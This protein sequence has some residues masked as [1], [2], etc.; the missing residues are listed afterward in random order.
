MSKNLWPEI[1][2]VAG[3][4]LGEGFDLICEGEKHSYAP[5]TITEKGLFDSDGDY[6]PGDLIGHIFDGSYTIQ[7]RPWR[8]KNNEVFWLVGI[9]GN[10]LCSCFCKNNVCDLG[11]LNMGNCFPTKEAAEATKPE[12][13]AKF[14][15]IKKGVRE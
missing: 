3:V 2:K 15:E 7:K 5:Y 14:E 6:V 10:V 12:M 13:L 11:I 9:S 1:A 8:P 4:E